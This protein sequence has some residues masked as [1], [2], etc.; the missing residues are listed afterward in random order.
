[1]FAAWSSPTFRPLVPGESWTARWSAVNESPIRNVGTA[2]RKAGIPMY[3]ASSAPVGSG[4]PITAGSCE[5]QCATRLEY[6]GSSGGERT[7]S[8]TKRPETA[9]IAHCSNRKVRSGRAGNP[10]RQAPTRLPAASPNKYT[11]SAV[12]NVNAVDLTPMST[13]RN[14]SISRDSAQKPES[15]YRPSQ[16]ANG[17]RGSATDTGAECV[18]GSGSGRA[19]RRPAASARRPAS[20]LAAA[21]QASAPGSPRC[22]SSSQGV[23]SAPS[24]APTTFTP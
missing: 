11:A 12:P 21:A 10:S 3:S 17:S 9:A 7:R 6:N 14:Q 19:A 20:A 15:A 4:P 22:R 5:R 2:H 1:M 23:A 13:M 24:P 8:A 16:A 18:S